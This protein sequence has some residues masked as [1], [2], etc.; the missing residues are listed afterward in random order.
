M[1]PANTFP[2]PLTNC[3]NIQDNAAH[4]WWISGKNKAIL[5]HCERL[6]QF[7]SAL[8]TTPSFFSFNH[9]IFTLSSTSRYNFP[10]CKSHEPGLALAVAPL[11]TA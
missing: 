4:G 9:D 2:N 3:F 10:S 8:L 6:V 1:M 5:Y 11:L 7:A